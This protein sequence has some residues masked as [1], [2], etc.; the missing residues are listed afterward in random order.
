MRLNKAYSAYAA[1]LHTISYT[2][3][4]SLDEKRSRTRLE[5]TS[6]SADV[7]QRSFI[8]YSM[9]FCYTIE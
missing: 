2:D 4:L 5:R 9:Q 8:G 1:K 6:P 3:T 7:F